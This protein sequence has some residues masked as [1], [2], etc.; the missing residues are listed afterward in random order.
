MQLQRKLHYF[1]KYFSIVAIIYIISNR[2][3]PG[4][5]LTNHCTIQFH[6]HA[7]LSCQR[8]SKLFL[9]LQFTFW[10]HSALFCSTLLFL[11]SVITPLRMNERT[12]ELEFVLREFCF[13]LT[14]SLMAAYVPSATHAHISQSSYRNLDCSPLI[15]GM[16]V[17]VCGTC[18]LIKI[19]IFTTKLHTQT[20]RHIH[21]QI[22]AHDA[23][24]DNGVLCDSEQ[25]PA[26]S[27]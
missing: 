9:L 6:V 4:C 7:K 25:G 27:V 10:F 1:R 19:K 22:L 5:T 18:T 26:T 15:N 2:A 11:R 3:G 21:S 8:G 16:C 13:L 23:H 24:T 20:H 14:L 17:A 12:M